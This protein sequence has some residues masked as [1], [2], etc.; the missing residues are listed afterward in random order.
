MSIRKLFIHVKASFQPE[1]FQKIR[2][3]ESMQRLLAKLKTKQET[4]SHI[5][6]E[7]LGKKDLA[8]LKKDL[9]IITLQIKKGEHIL[10]KLSV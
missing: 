5:S 9:V 4:F 1:K 3:K 6:K 7:N 2:K 8:E 10:E